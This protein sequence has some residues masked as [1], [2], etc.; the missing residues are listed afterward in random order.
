MHWTGS[1]VPLPPQAVSSLE[2]R[3]K[4]WAFFPAFLQSFHLPADKLDSQAELSTLAAALPW[5]LP[6]CPQQLPDLGQGVHC[7]L[8]PGRSREP[9]T[10]PRIEP[11]GLRSPCRPFQVG[12]SGEGPSAQ[13]FGKPVLGFHRPTEASWYLPCPVAV[14]SVP[15]STRSPE[16]A[17]VNPEVL[18]SI[19]S[20]DLPGT[21]L[22]GQSL[23]L[24]ASDAEA[25]G[26]IP[27][28]GTKI[29]NAHRV[30]KKYI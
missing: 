9:C 23:R 5:G 24:W 27:G 8:D 25:A 7:L 13:P 29:P 28:G 30:A 6:H 15:R 12:L 4:F 17:G 3:I 11:L 22:A 20:L 10:A 16:P 2:E 19:R 1:R 14:G 26:S 18:K 21:S